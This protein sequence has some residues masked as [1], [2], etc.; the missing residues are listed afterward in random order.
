MSEQKSTLQELEEKFENKR[1]DPDKRDAAEKVPTGEEVR[2]SNLNPPKFYDN[3]GNLGPNTSVP[4]GK[5]PDK[6]A[7]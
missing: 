5:D 3:P 4:S 6:P 1:N 7:R 2:N